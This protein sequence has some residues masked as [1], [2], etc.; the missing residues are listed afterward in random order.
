MLQPLARASAQVRNSKYEADDDQRIE[1][2]RNWPKTAEKVAKIRPIS[3]GTR[4]LPPIRTDPR[5]VARMIAAI[6][7]SDSGFTQELAHVFHLDNR[8]DGSLIACP[9]FTNS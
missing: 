4:W 9:S 6:T 8:D 3:T 2:D 7:Q 5:T 1:K